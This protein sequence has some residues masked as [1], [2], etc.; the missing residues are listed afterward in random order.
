MEVKYSNSL[1]S[2]FSQNTEEWAIAN[3]Y[4]FA[5]ELV[6]EEDSARIWCVKLYGKENNRACKKERNFL[7]SPKSGPSLSPE[8]DDMVH[9]FN[10]SDEIWNQPSYAWQEGFCLS[11]NRW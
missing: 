3:S 2:S 1:K 4:S 7:P 9:V 11:K 10:E 5:Q 6:C 8:T